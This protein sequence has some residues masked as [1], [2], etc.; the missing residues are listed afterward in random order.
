MKTLKVCFVLDCTSSMDPW[1]KAAKNKILD[2]LEDIQKSHLDFKIYV[3]FIG[4][5]DFKEKKHVVEFTENYKLIYDCIKNIE[6]YG[7]GDQAEDVS[8]AYSIV[9]SLLWGAD[10]NVVFHITDAPEHG[11]RYHDNTV[12]DDFPDGNPVLELSEEIYDLARIGV[13]LTVFRL[14][15]STNIMFNWMKR[16]Y[17]AVDLSNFKIID[18]DCTTQSAESSFYNEVT[19]QLNESMTL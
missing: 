14:N 16:I 10:V 12:T 8:G 6:A 19:S 1:I 13:D 4:Y 17:E 5:R 18:F 15:K 2:I 9:N 3:A 7:G 11:L